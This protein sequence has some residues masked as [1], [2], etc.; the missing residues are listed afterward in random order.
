ML[1]NLFLS[2]NNIT[3]RNVFLERS[4][5]YMQTKLEWSFVGKLGMRKQITM[6]NAIVYLLFVQ[7]ALILSSVRALAVKGSVP[8]DALTFDKV[9]N[10]RGAKFC[11]LDML[12]CLT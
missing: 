5:V 1:I 9:I 3:M 7:V 2:I 4:N 10:F 12:V 6:N 11:R 8:L